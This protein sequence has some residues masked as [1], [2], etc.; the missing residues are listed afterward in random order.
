MTRIQ[1]D[2]RID[3]LALRVTADLI[4]YATEEEADPELDLLGGN[5]REAIWETAQDSEALDLDLFD[6]NVQ[7]ELTDRVRGLME[8]LAS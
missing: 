1:A 8:H 4:A 2:R 6:P 3:I 7:T 5:L